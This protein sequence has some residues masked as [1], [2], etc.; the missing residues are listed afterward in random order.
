M[1]KRILA[2]AVLALALALPSVSG[3]R[4]RDRDGDPWIH[5]EVLED[6]GEGAK[7]RANLPFSLAKVALGLAPGKI[8]DGNFQISE[9]HIRFEN[10]DVS[11][12]D[13][14][15]MWTELREAGEAEFVTV[16]EEDE[17]VRIFRRGDRLFVHVD[18]EDDERVRIEVP[19]A[20]VDALLS[21]PEDALD[22]EAALAELQ[23]M[24]GD[25]IIRVEDG[26]DIV[27]IW[28]D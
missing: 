21:G 13:I 20:L 4:D 16:E 5:V 22:L 6:G 10:E 8:S 3:A 23:K 19:L 7:V 12:E 1:R 24:E 2:M 17:T 28:I 11:V 9:G 18:G 25:E 27:R 15:K 26:E 14:R